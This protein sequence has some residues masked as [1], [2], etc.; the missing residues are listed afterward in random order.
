MKKLISLALTLALALSLS[1]CGG[2][3]A[4][5]SSVPSA[6]PGGES[7]APAAEP[8]V[9]NYGMSNAWDSLMPYNSPSG[10]N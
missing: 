5:P 1:A 3:P 7:A 9:V 8:R 2:S 6:A 4:A 10:S